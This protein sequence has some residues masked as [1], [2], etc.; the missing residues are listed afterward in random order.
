MICVA[1]TSAPRVM[2]SA[3]LY[4]GESPTGDSARE[5]GTSP[6]RNVGRNEKE[7]L[8][9]RLSRR[10]VL[11][12][13]TGV[14]TFGILHWHKAD[15]AEFT[16]KIAH[17]LPPTHP[18]HLRLMQGAK[19]IGEEAGGKLVVQVYPNGQLGSDSQML[20]QVR[21][22]ALE[23]MMIGD[24]ILG[25]VVPSASIASLPFAFN[26]YQQLWSTMD[27]AF[28]AYIHAKVAAIGL[29]AFDKGWDVGFRHVIT[30]NR[31][32]HNAGDMKGLKL[33]V[34]EAPIQVSFFRALGASPT[35]INISEL[36]TGL[37]THLVDGA[38]LPLSSIESAK[39]YEVTKQISLTAHQ[40]T[41]YEALANG[42]AY[43]RLP[44]NLQEILARNL[45]AMALLER[46][47]IADGETGLAATLKTQGETI[48]KPDRKSFRA[49]IQHAGLYAKW[50]DT[51]GK[52]PF[53]L[54]EKAVGKLA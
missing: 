36:Y 38:E 16:Y 54:L 24:N 5:P 25:Q 33:R 40:P 7:A 18:I 13:A 53:A 42:A 43:Q 14:A 30:T 22:G 48:I 31:Q 12:G 45:D 47:D 34:P 19:K 44:K 11:A 3:S 46:A 41:T 35:P 17:D 51:Y 37:Q 10:T 4:E 6:R 9:M 27:G 50:R 21:S 26:G 52:E 2:L 15:A 28:G 20:A 8:G 29:H 49:V 1:G 23:V 32:V 39:F